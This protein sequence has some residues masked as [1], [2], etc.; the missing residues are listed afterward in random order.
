MT[1]A[2]AKKRDLSD[3]YNPKE[4][5]IEGYDYIVWSEYEEKST[6][7]EELIAEE[8]SITTEELVDIPPMPPF[9]GD[10]EEVKEEQGLKFLTPSKLFT[11]LPILLTK[12]K[13][14]N[15]SNKL[16]NEIR[17]IQYLVYQ[18]RKISKIVFYNLIKLLES[19]RKIKF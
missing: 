10:E 6:D 12:I 17:Q 14:T 2:D 18:H 11:R 7:K 5:F 1:L 9:K 4:L 15:N 19:W 3:K 8:E 16:K 13:V